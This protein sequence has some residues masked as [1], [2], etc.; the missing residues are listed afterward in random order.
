MNTEYSYLV[1]DKEWVVDS[2]FSC[3]FYLVFKTHVSNNYWM[4]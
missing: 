2:V 1:D 4:P 3:V